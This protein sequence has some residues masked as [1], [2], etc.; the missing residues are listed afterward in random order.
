MITTQDNSLLTYDQWK[1]A[2]LNTLGASEVGVVV[3][4]NPWTSNL[5]LF[6]EKIGG[7][8]DRVENIRMFM[9][10]QTEDINR[11]LYEYYEGTEQS[12]VDNHRAGKK[13]R[14]VINL[15]ATF[16]NDKYSHL[17]VTP[18]G[19]IQDYGVYAGHGKGTYENKNTTSWYLNS[20]E[21]GLPTDNVLQLCTQILVCEY[22][23]GDLFYFIDN[24]KFQLHHIEK[25]ALGN[26]EETILLHTIP[27]WDNVLKARPLYNQLYEAQRNMNQRLMAELQKEIASLEPPAQNTT[28]YLNF[29]SQKYKDKM[30][31][32]GIMDGT[33]A[34]L[35]VARRHKELG[36]QIVELE[37]QRRMME[38]ELKNIIGDKHTLNFGANGK[39]TWAADKTGKRTFLNK[40]KLTT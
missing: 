13:V 22:N 8:R 5:E 2:R 1:V 19:E 3:Y 28:G 20:F 37:G 24:S 9:G 35:Q 11:K 7:G 38:V 32:M 26:I 12:V 34:M 23:Y 29:L 21:S 15:D 30:A 18:D 36:N 4:G 27:F 31:G 33:E 6:Y 39:V 40:V 16:F 17:S 25:E 10:K 14:Q